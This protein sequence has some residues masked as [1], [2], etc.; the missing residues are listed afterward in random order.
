MLITSRSSKVRVML[1]IVV[2]PDQNFLAASNNSNQFVLLQ[3]Q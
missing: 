3:L 1:L 2:I